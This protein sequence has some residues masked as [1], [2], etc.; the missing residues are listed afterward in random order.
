MK[1]ASRELLAPRDDVWEFLA[2]PHHL[3]DWWPGITGVGPDRR[4]FA[5]GARW[6]VLLIEGGLGARRSALRRPSG[7]RVTAKLLV[8]RVA[9]YEEWS[10]QLVRSGRAILDLHPDRCQ[11]QA[12]VDRARSNA[13]DGG[14]EHDGFALPAAPPRPGRVDCPHRCESSLRPRPDRRHALNELA[15]KK[16]AAGS[17]VPRTATTCEQS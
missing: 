13:R 8:T 10:W 3:A 11:R 17:R 5:A 15:G 14:C 2:E 4:G 6:D 7:P 1:E 12:E 9:L 16:W